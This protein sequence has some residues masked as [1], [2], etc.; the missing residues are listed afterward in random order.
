MLRGGI[1]ISKMV[2]QAVVALL[3]SF[4]PIASQ[5][6]ETPTFVS[7]I[8]TALKQNNGNQFAALKSLAAP[9]SLDF[10]E[11]QIRE[12]A[13]R[14]LGLWGSQNANHFDEILV[15]LDQQSKH[16][17]LN[18][19]A[20][21]AMALLS[22]NEFLA[23]NNSPKTGPVTNKWK[24]L[25]ADPSYPVMAKIRV[26]QWM[27]HYSDHFNDSKGLLISVVTTQ[28]TDPFVCIS[29]AFSILK[30]HAPTPHEKSTISA[31]LRGIKNSRRLGLDDN[32][33]NFL[34]TLTTAYASAPKKKRQRKEQTSDNLV[35]P[36]TI[37]PDPGINLH[38]TSVFRSV[39]SS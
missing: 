3:L 33:T 24:S 13:L 8:N 34:T 39:T 10:I 5:A 4:N 38:C 2:L 31:K 21:D 28:N 11:T 14:Q 20:I 30:F 37:D 17:S 16:E 26:L 19:A 6:A 9:A 23:T 36:Y 27:R 18:L 1:G 7:A 29:A 35:A 12:E 32:T 15:L 25:L 22:A